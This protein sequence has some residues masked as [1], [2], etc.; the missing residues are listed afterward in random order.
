MSQYLEQLIALLP[1]DIPHPTDE[2]VRIMQAID[3]EDMESDKELSAM[4]GD[5]RALIR[6]NI[7]LH[8]DTYCGYDSPLHPRIVLNSRH[9]LTSVTPEIQTE[10]AR[11]VKFFEQAFAP[12][13]GLTHDGYTFEDGGVKSPERIAQKI[14]EKTSDDRPNPQLTDISRMRIVTPEFRALYHV[15]QRLHDFLQYRDMILVESFD[16][17]LDPNRTKYASDFRYINTIWQDKDATERNLL[18]SEIQLMTKRMRAI[19]DLNHPFDATKVVQYPTKEHEAWLRR[20]ILKAAV[21][22][23]L[24]RR[25]V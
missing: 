21:L 9:A 8:W 17:Y 1:D 10:H 2:H 25:V 19:A 16:K 18:Y 7:Q 12:D 14:Y 23:A 3:A 13:G 5:Q 6:R 22:D 20:L 15:S 11:R 4:L 24:R